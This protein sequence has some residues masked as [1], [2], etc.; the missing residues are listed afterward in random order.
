MYTRIVDGVVCSSVFYEKLWRLFLRV[1]MSGEKRI[2]LL[3]SEEEA[4]EK[5][6]VRRAQSMLAD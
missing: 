4:S 3:K 1:R 6:K 5:K 2:A